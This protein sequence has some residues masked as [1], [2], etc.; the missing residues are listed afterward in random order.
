MG[1]VTV[2]ESFVLPKLIPQFTVLP[3]ASNKI[4]TDKNKY[5]LIYM[6]QNSKRTDL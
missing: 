2:I 6:K 4:I 3:N 1:K 5:V